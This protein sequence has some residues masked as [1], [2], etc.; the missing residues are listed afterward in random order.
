MVRFHHPLQFLVM[1]NF[2]KIQNEVKKVEGGY[3][4]NPNDNRNWTGWKKGVGVLLGT[5][6]GIA[7]AFWQKNYGYTTQE[8]VKNAKYEQALSIYK[9]EFWNPLDLD[10]VIDE[11]V[12]HIIYDGKV[13]HY[14]GFIEKV[15]K[16]SLGTTKYDVSA[17][18]KA[19][20]EVLFN[21]IKEAR[22]KEYNRLSQKSQ[23]ADFIKGWLNRIRGFNYRGIAAEAMRTVKENKGK[24]AIFL[25]FT[26]L[27][28]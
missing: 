12:A 28:F 7:A 18:N 15:V 19:N 4:A 10:S 22:E 6:F 17:I 2:K 13:N 3:T 26:S 14:S 1:A 27:F 11:R 9:K 21:K 16:D 20:P 25:A 23:N 8:Q 5:N 24:V